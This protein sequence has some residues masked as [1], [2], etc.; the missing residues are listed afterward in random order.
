MLLT[1]SLMAGCAGSDGAAGAN[2]TNGTD[3]TAGAK[4]ETCTLCHVDVLAPPDS[5]HP[6]VPA[7]IDP[8]SYAASIDA[9]TV[10]SSGGTT[11]FT[12]DFTVTSGGVYVPTL[13]NRAAPDAT[14]KA[15]NNL[16]YLRFAYAKLITN[17]G[18]AGETRWVSYNQGERAFANLTDNGDST[19]TYVCSGLTATTGATVY[20]PAVTTRIGLQI[21]TA[22]GITS[23]PLQITQDLVP[24]DLPT[25]GTVA[26]TRDIVATTAC[27]ECHGTRNGI[28]HGT[29][30]ETKYCVVCHTLETK[31]NGETVEFK[32]MI[33]QIHTSQTRSFLDSA[34]LTYPQDVLNCIKCHKGSTE[35]NNW[36]T[37]PSIEACGSCHTTIDFA[38]GVGHSG[39]AA[40]NADCTG[41]HFIGATLRK[42]P[43]VAHVTV[44]ATPNNPNVPTGDVNFAYEI[45]LVT[46]SSTTT[47]AAVNPIIKFRILA[48]ENATPSTPVTFATFTTGA[49]MLTVGT[50]TFSGSP[51]F[52]VAFALPQEGLAN[53]A[54]TMNDFNN[55]G[56]AAAQ[57]ASVSITNLWNGTQGTL[58]GPAAGGWYTAT[59]TSSSAKFPAGAKMRT[60]ALQGYFTQVDTNTARHT[61][62]ILGTVSGDTVRRSVVDPAKCA[63]CHEWFEGHGGNRNIGSAST[64]IVVCVV[65]HNPN[66]SSSGRGA[67]PATVLSRMTVSDQVKMTAAG[68]DPAKP[69]TYPEESMN[70]K[71]LIHATHASGIR[72]EPFRFVRDRGTSGVFYYDMSEVTFP[73]RIGDC[74][75]CHKPGTYN[76]PTTPGLLSSTNETTDGLVSTPVGSDRSTVPNAADITTSPATAACIT[77][78]T[79]N[80]PVTHINAQGGSVKVKRSNDLR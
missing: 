9:V 63:N 1:M 11:T 44:N 21:A 41:C 47:L 56:K 5:I 35:G 28:A 55:L 32:R 40:T 43:A 37:Q 14:G 67:D 27:A 65:C 66:L 80:V 7:N 29:R 72:T 3:L 79:T 34:E 6:N 42:D 25:L 62:S 61:L 8:S 19:Y 52:L 24:N 23:K 31:R 45:N 26:A 50:H 73:G 22:T 76:L 53:N 78:H 69:S 59:I 58:T 16:A 64:G 75:T 57:P 20:D 46:A 12:I 54:A 48:N 30:Y 38:T 36:R 71:D 13:A 2:G 33:H 77:C 49:T 18:V 60:I 70:L 74:E 4:A 15:S 17:P 51:S 39:G 10:L 68:F